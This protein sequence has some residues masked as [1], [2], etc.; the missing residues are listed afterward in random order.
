VNP[1]AFRLELPSNLKIHNV[2]HMSLLK[3]VAP[4]TSLSAPPTPIMVDGDLEYEVE[5]IASHRFLGHGKLQFLVKW[6]GY[7]VEHNTWEPEANRAN[8]PE[9]VSE[10]WSAVQSQSGMRLVSS[11]TAHRK[12]QQ[13]KAWQRQHWMQHNW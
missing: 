5:S 8:C 4:G 9:K 1:V 12:Q 2:I 7:G 10:Y 6:L 11:N 3:P 13:Q